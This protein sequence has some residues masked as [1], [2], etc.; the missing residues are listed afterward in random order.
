MKMGEASW[1]TPH[2][3]GRSGTG[4]G[5]QDEQRRWLTHQ[6]AEQPQQHGVLETIAKISGV[7]GVAIVHVTLRRGTAWSRTLAGS[8]QMPSAEPQTVIVAQVR[9]QCVH[10][11]RII[12][13]DRYG[14]NRI[15]FGAGLLRA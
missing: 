5:V 1:S 10:K 4:M 6:C 7:E 13:P 9:R 11:P 3:G 12:S 8:S 15:L 2:A 14:T